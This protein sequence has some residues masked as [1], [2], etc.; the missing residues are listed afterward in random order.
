MWTRSNIFIVAAFILMF[1]YTLIVGDVITATGLS[2]LPW[3]AFSAFFLASLV[4]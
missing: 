3:A 1:L 4:G 2:W